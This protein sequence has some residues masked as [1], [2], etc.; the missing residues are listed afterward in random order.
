MSA[1][2]V[3]V[4]AGP[5]GLCSAL[6]LSR[7]GHQ[8]TLIERD[9]VTDGS[10][11]TALAWERGGV[12]HFE[13]PHAFIPRGRLEMRETLPD[14]YEELLNQ[15]ARQLPFLPQQGPPQAGDE[16]LTYLGVRR[17][18]IEWALRRALL[19]DRLVDV[20]SGTRATGLLVESGQVPRVS[21]VV[22]GA[23]ATACDLVI[24]AGGRRS[25]L[26]GWLRQAGA[27]LP[28]QTTE[29]GSVYYSRY[30]QMLPGSELPPLSASLGPRGDLGYCA[31]VTFPGDNQT[32]GYVLNVPTSQPEFR[33]LRHPAAFSAFCREV[34]QLRDWVDLDFARP[35]TDVVPMGSLQNSI[36]GWN[37]GGRPA[38]TG[39]LP[40]SDA[41]IHTDPT[42]AL[43]LC[44]SLIHARA[45]GSALS[46]H[47]ANVE[48]VALDYFTQ[49]IPEA[50]ECYRLA[51]AIAEARHRRWAGDLAFGRDSNL[52]FFIMVAGGVAAQHDAEIFRRVVRRN[53]FLDRTSVMEED[54]EMLARIERIFMDKRSAP[55][56]APDRETMLHHLTDA[57]GHQ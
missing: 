6:V 40:V 32:F 20:V 11:E 36:I 42:F 54:E 7:A 57:L 46:R 51:S 52:A 25:P 50:E 3:V 15:N 38:A 8:V 34:P 1:K 18:M 16:A 55:P 31:F 22:H 13:S 49:A 26:A 23:G 33:V 30:F 48:D 37:D 4:G 9:S 21:G 12:P 56:P 47:G 44:N 39:L 19:R 24:D 10:P 5:A 43:G 29:V 45:I 27:T 17:P 53:G 2:I 14:V 28:V 35:V 41:W